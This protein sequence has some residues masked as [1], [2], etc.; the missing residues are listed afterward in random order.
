MY[1]NRIRTQNIKPLIVN[2]IRPYIDRLMS[3]DFVEGIVLLGGL[4]DSDSKNF[5]DKFSDVDMA[6]FIHG[7]K[8]DFHD[9]EKLPDF[10]FHIPFESRTL[11]IN[12]HQ[13][14]CEDEKSTVW[15]EGKKEVYTNTSELIFDKNGEVRRII[16][17]HISFD[18]NY[19]CSR[20]SII[21]SQYYWVK[22]INRQVERGFLLNAMYMINYGIDLFIEGLYIYNRRYRPHPK[23][24]IEIAKDL[25][26]LPKDFEY[27]LQKAFLVNDIDELCIF[28][29]NNHL[30]ILFSE[31]ENRIISDGIFNGLKPHDY[32]CLYGYADRQIAEGNM[33]SRNFSHL[34]SLLDERER[35][36]FNGLV[37]EHLLNTYDELIDME[38][39]SIPIEY[40]DIISKITNRNNS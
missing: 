10:D 22:N 23:W 7:H 15:D 26:W 1:I 5:M 9:F 11:K 37:N 17:S 8:S 29:R 35:N 4:S 19:R 13:Q 32:A 6:I 36:L 39:D 28:E 18:E 20:L 2:R 31:L 27:H 25:P 16:E 24:R 12:V 14:F 21:L 40:K 34:L 3:L 38:S 30:C 33:A